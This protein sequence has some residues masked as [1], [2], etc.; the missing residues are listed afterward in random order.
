MPNG[1]MQNLF[2]G[3]LGVGAIGLAAMGRGGSRQVGYD[4]ETFSEG[5]ARAFW[6][7][8]YIREVEEA[9]QEDALGP[10]AGGQWMDVLPQTPKVAAQMGKAFTAAFRRALPQV[11]VALQANLPDTRLA[12]HYAAM[13]AMGHGVGLADYNVDVQVPSWESWDLI[14]VAINAVGQQG[15]RA[16]AP[17]LQSGYA[18]TS[19]RRHP[20]EPELVIIDEKEI[21]KATTFVGQAMID[22]IP[23]VAYKIP[24][25]NRYYFQTWH[26]RIGR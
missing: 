7:D 16:G 19:S 20:R 26:A 9:G 21:G 14:D 12:G 4:W 24:G 22:G 6:A 15:S 8:A 13:E 25:K 23:H 18:H 5:A 3:A 2:L 11:A 17:P 10:G 1:Q